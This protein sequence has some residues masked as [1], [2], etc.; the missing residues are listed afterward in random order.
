[1][2]LRS[3][4]TIEETWPRIGS[5]SFSYFL[6]AVRRLRTK[7]MS[8]NVVKAVE[9]DINRTINR[10]LR[11]LRM[12]HYGHGFSVC[13]LASADGCA[14]WAAMNVCPI[15]QAVSFATV[16]PITA[17]ERTIGD[18]V[19][20]APLAAYI[21]HRVPRFSFLGALLGL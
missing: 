17:S 16:E 15:Y 8:L 18:R 13:S 6:F 20:T 12:P 9:V 14:P 1:M 11:W 19:T 3:L 5:L 7:F 2:G 21:L 10:R 4:R